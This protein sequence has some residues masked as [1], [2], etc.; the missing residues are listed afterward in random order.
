ML[1]HYF[2]RPSTVDRL[3]SLWLGPSLS[4]YAEWLSDRQI[5]RAS[6][7]FKIQ[8][9]V[10]FDRFVTDR[11]VRTLGELPTQIEP[12]VKEWRRTRG[13]RPHT[14]SYA[15]PPRAGPRTAVEEVLGLVLPARVG[16]LHRQP[17]PLPALA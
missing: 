4:R 10:L 3:R 12:F 7:L 15:R 5:S 17:L 11:H 2:T 8:T 13:R 9:L 1:E 6:A 16:T 14:A